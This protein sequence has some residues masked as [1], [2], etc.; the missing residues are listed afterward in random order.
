M[1][2]WAWSMVTSSLEPTTATSFEGAMA[3]CE[4]WDGMA[5]VLLYMGVLV[6]TG[7]F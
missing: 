7:F 3:S 1:C 4:L 2:T 6:R 5:I